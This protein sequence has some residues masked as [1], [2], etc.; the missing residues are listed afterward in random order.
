MYI[1]L[2][3]VAFI[4]FG[5][6]I[7]TGKISTSK[8]FKENKGIFTF[9]QEKDYEFLLRAKYG[10]RV[11]DVNQVFRKRVFQGLIT[12]LIVNFIGYLSFSLQSYIIF[13]IYPNINKV[14]GY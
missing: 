11:Y 3:L 5:I 13:L 7:Y 12:I 10:E 8:F 4:I 14:S 1:E 9:L 2:L 6:L